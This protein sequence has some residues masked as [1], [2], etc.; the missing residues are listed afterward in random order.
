MTTNATMEPNMKGWIN[1]GTGWKHASGRAEIRSTP[2][3][4]F[5]CSIDGEE[6]KGESGRTCF[7]GSLVNAV[8]AIVRELPEVGSVE[9]EQ[10][11]PPETVGT[12]ADAEKMDRAPVH[13]EEP[14]PDGTTGVVGAKK[15]KAPKAKRDKK[16]SESLSPDAYGEGISEPGI[17]EF[18]F[19]KLEFRI[20]RGTCRHWYAFRSDGSPVTK[21]G[22]AP[23]FFRK[24]R[25]AIAA[26]LKAA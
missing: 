26:L 8:A 2:G 1:V 13:R 16:P 14:L 19:G 9:I 25:N 15:A 12:P 24:R 23:A 21:D 6:L 17:E 4:R 5:A 11:P 7:F 20:E 18:P 3:G 10:L 22:V